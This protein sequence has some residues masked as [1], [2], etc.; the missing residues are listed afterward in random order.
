MS[1]LEFKINEIITL[2]LENNRTNI[3][4]N[5]ELFRHCKYLLLNIPVDNIHE[6][7]DITSIDEAEEYLDHSLEREAY[8]F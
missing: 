4:V 6:F 7:D 3:Y 5:N 1:S 2:K 8:K